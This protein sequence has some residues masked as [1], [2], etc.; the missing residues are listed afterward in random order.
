M[1]K[2][3]DEIH[4]ERRWRDNRERKEKKKNMH[5]VDVI[6]PLLENLSVCI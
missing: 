4:E 1:E 3:N 5:L 6:P 2:F